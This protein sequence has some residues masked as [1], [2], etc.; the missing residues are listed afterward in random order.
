MSADD[1]MK[2][3]SENQDL[4]HTYFYVHLNKCV[5]QTSFTHLNTQNKP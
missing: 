4:C 1:D 3:S 2:Q 5:L